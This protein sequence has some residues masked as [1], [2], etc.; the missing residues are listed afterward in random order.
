M[1]KK[2]WIFLALWAISNCSTYGQV[3]FE[4]TDDGNG[5]INIVGS[6]SAVIPKRATQFFNIGI[7][8]FGCNFNDEA[9]QDLCKNGYQSTINGAT[10]TT[11][12]YPTISTFPIDQNSSLTFNG[13]NLN[14]FFSYLPLKAVHKS[15]F[16]GKKTQKE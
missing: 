12:D 6:G 10:W 14:Q 3:V 7:N 11:A 13:F 1:M 5:G 15:E 8:N 16:T 2:L 9:F 4:I